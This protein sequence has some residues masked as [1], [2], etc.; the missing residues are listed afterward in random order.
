[1]KKVKAIIRRED[2]G[3]YLAT[4]A[5]DYGLGYYANGVGN[6]VEETKASLLDSYAEIKKYY[7]EMGNKFTEIDIDFDFEFETAAFEL[8][9]LVEKYKLL[10]QQG[11]SVGTYYEFE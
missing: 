9:E 1:M 10:K 7:E 6:T 2:D 4:F 5:E 3:S 8:V 11:A